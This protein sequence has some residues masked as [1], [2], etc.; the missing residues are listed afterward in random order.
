MRS[1][2]NTKSNFEHRYCPV[3][4]LLSAQHQSR[5][6]DG[7]SRWR[8]SAKPSFCE[9]SI[10]RRRRRLYHPCCAFRHRN[11]SRKGIYPQRHKGSEYSL[12]NNGNGKAQYDL[13]MNFKLMEHILNEL[14][15]I[16]E[17]CLL[18]SPF[19]YN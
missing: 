8:F 7:I 14:P 16:S 12:V 5:N 3:L 9:T 6:C 17:F 2:V 15:N 11:D 10:H 19:G 18:E 4:R 1:F 13:K